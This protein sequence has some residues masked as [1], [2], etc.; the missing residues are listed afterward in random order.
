MD[1]STKNFSEKAKMLFNT[2]KKD[3]T[4]QFEVL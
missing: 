4:V 2:M 1:N 3:G